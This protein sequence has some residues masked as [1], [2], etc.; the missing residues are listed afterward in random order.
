MQA[1]YAELNTDDDGGKLA[2][3]SLANVL[4]VRLIQHVSAP[5]C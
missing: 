1:V 3:E 5:R 4:A 2:A